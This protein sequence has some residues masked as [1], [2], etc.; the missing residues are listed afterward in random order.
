MT[1]HEVTLD[2]DPDAVS[3]VVEVL[4]QEVGNVGD[5]S[6]SFHLRLGIHEMLL[7]AI[8][9]GNLEISAQEKRHAIEKD[10][11]DRLL[12]E[13]RGDPRYSARRVRVNITHDHEHGVYACCIRDEGK[14]FNWKEWISRQAA[15]DSIDS[16][17]W[18]GIALTQRAAGILKYNDAGNEVMLTVRV[19]IQNNE[20]SF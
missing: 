14:G 15:C 3:R 8:E 1:L 18:R 2:N 16:G 4:L 12:A 9:H 11:Y 17:C 5:E 19:G 6:T 13:R 10:Q 20:A 7:N